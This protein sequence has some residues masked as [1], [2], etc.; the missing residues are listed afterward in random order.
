MEVRIEESLASE[1]IPA[2]L[3]GAV[4]LLALALAAV[5][6]YGILAYSVSQRTREIGIRMALGSSRRSVLW[7][8]ARE[9]LLLVVLGGLAGVGISIAAWRLLSQHVPGV[10]QIDAPILI[11]CASIMLI[12]AVTAVSTRYPRMSSVL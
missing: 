4:G 11:T 5:G 2:N 8:V 3:S 10:S 12:L 7:M 9:A 6:L 1:R